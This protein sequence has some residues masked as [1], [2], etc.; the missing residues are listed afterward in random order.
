MT[1]SSPPTSRPQDSASAG[2][3]AGT[4]L[5]GVPVVAGVQYAP[6]I[7]PGRLP[8]VDGGTSD[9]SIDE[10]DRPAEA[11]RFGAAATAVATRLRDRAAHATGAAS[12][13]LAA[14]ATLAQ[15]RAWL[16]AAEKRIKEGTP[17][18]RAVA[19]AVEQFVAMFTQLGGLMAERVTD[20]QDIRDRVIAELS[21]LPEPGVPLPDSPSILCAEDLAPAD[22]AGLDPNLVVALATTLGGPTSHTAII[23][24][25]LGIPCVVAVAGLDPVAAGTMVLVDG[26]LGTVTVSPDHA[27]AGEAVAMA[28]REAERA[29]CAGSRP[30]R[31]ANEGDP[32]ARRCRD[33]RDRRHLGRQRHSGAARGTLT[34]THS[35]AF[36]CLANLA[37]SDPLLPDRSIGNIKAIPAGSTPR[38]A[39]DVSSARRERPGAG[40]GLR[41]W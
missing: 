26:T 1:A 16:G 40:N 20:L 23:A 37:S 10:A 29:A 14:T 34:R 28:Q 13:V 35:H 18:A 7:R 11:A 32:R 5:R 36:H 19:A 17:A 4:V 15:D 38:E 30:A 41:A 8:V 33:A 39:A 12:E 9:A 27:T 25:Q 2:Y 22:T 24:R 31:A 6:V 3:P 21:G